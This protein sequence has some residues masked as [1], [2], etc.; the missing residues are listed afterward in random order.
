M[1][2]QIGVG[3]RVQHPS[4]GEGII[5]SIDTS[6]LQV[7]FKSYGDKEISRQFDGLEIIEP[8]Q[9]EYKGLSLFDVEKALKKVLIEHA[10][11]QHMVEL[12]EKWK[13][14]NVAIQPFDPELQAKDIPIDTFFHKIV[15]VRDRL[16]VLEQNINS[17]K[18][19]TDE[20][21]VHLQQYISRAYGSLTTFNVLFKRKEDQFKGAGK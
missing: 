18:V 19:L 3:A 9:T 20:E 10:D 8:A 7:F 6:T 4:F 12:G 16:R 11:M 14:G 21:K 5:V 15:M 2:A 1:A 13:G 17:H